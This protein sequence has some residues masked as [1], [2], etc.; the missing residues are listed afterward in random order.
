MKNNIIALL[1]LSLCA[2]AF[3]SFAQEAAP[4][5]APAPAEAASS[6]EVD[7]TPPDQKEVT[8]TENNIGGN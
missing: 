6:P 1:G 3:V 4:A 8:E 5:P 7:G 2:P